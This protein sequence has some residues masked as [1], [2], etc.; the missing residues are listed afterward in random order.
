MYSLADLV[1]AGVL[2][3]CCYLSP[4][5]RDFGHIASSK[6][7]SSAFSVV[8]SAVNRVDSG[9]TDTAP[10]P[11]LVHAELYEKKRDLVLASPLR[12]KGLEFRRDDSHEVG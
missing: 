11:I 10:F 7:L 12:T 8:A 1:Q 6:E 5:N 3:F 2:A 4:P 9:S